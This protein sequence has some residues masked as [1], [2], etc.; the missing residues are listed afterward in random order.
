MDEL[1]AYVQGD[2][3]IPLEERQFPDDFCFDCHE[4]NEH[5]S[6]DQVIQLTAGLELNPHDSHLGELECSTC[7]KMHGPSE[8]YC[9]QCHGAVATG[10]GW[11]TE[12]TATAEV[13]VWSPDMDCTVCHVMDPYVES[14]DNPDLLAYAHA[15]QGLECLDCHTDLEELRK[16]HEEAIPGRPIRKLTVEMDFCFDCHV[17]NEHTSYEQVIELTKDYV[18]D[19]QNINPHDPHV[20]LESAEHNLGPYQCSSCHKMHEESPPIEGCYACHHDGTFESC[21]KCH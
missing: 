10:P 8:D 20:G 1:V 9:A 15:Q 2:F 5:T 3:T 12:V 16:V 18:I 13:Q 6:Y 17:D 21:S 11:T 7:H 19:D 4:P 14:L